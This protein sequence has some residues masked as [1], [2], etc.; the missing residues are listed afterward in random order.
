MIQQIKIPCSPAFVP[1]SLWTPSTS[2]QEEVSPALPAGSRAVE[3]V[4]K[5]SNEAASVPAEKPDSTGSFE[6]AEKGLSR[7]E[8]ADNCTVKDSNEA[9]SAPVE[10]ADSTGSFKKAEEGL[11]RDESADNCTVSPD[12]RE[13]QMDSPAISVEM[14]QGRTSSVRVETLAPAILGDS[15]VDSVEVAGLEGEDFAPFILNLDTVFSKA[16]EFMGDRW[17]CLSAGDFSVWKQQN[18]L[19]DHFVG[20][21][22]VG[23]L[24]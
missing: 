18:R 11:S 12:G 14:D 8:S 1:A 24:R 7:D 2:I 16:S 21:S 3:A 6:K 22:A 13:N 20:T 23:C 4:N 9:A 10:K 19:R 17:S 5:D 15:S